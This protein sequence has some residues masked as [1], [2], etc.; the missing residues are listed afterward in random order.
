MGQEG[1]E[2][3]ELVPPFGFFSWSA[4]NPLREGTRPNSQPPALSPQIPRFLPPVRSPAASSPH[5]RAERTPRSTW[6]QK[7]SR[8]VA[9]RQ[10]KT[11][12][13]PKGVS[14]EREELPGEGA[15][16]SGQRAGE[17]TPGSLLHQ[18]RRWRTRRLA[19]GTGDRGE[20]FWLR[21]SRRN[22]SSLS[23]LPRA[24]RL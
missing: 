19:C 20:S 1:K 3:G 13:V 12:W 8:E 21:L 4:L 14:R 22:R 10:G 6:L 5:R 7:K 18:R 2:T 11:Q 17:G 16:G 23:L 9:R 24:T 15:L